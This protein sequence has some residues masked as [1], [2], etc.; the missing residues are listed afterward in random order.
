MW[1]RDSRRAECWKS[2]FRCPRMPRSRVW[3][4]PNDFLPGSREQGSFPCMPIARVWLI[5]VT[6]ARTV[7]SNKDLASANP[8][9]PRAPHGF[10]EAT[11]TMPE[12]SPIPLAEQIP[13][14]AP[15]PLERLRTLDISSADFPDKVA[16]LLRDEAYQECVPNLQGGNLTWLVEF[17]DNV[18]LQIPSPLSPNTHTI[19]GRR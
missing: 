14:P 11:A 17:L 12:C 16:K 15:V 9:V 19:T 13:M 18:Y 4:S 2:P 8:C 10:T 5:F 7:F 3:Q 1:M 6:C